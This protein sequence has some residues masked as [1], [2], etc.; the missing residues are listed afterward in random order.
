MT[1]LLP[2][3]YG[4]GHDCCGSVEVRE[5]WSRKRAGWCEVVGGIRMRVT[6]ESG[7]CGSRAVRERT[8]RADPKE[9]RVWQRVSAWCIA[10]YMYRITTWTAL[11]SNVK[12]EGWLATAAQENMAVTRCAFGSVNR[13]Q[14][15]FQTDF[16]APSLLHSSFATVSRTTVGF[17]PH[18]TDRLIY[19]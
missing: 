9:C 12:K 7:G 13:R 5:G 18:L 11:T 8:D 10:T 6:G 16:D 1:G 2:L 17:Q 14:P 4:R 15:S 19:D 3:R